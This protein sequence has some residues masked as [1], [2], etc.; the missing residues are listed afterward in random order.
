MIL[1]TPVRFQGRP[2]VLTRKP[3]AV[4]RTRIVLKKSIGCCKNSAVLCR[5]SIRFGGISTIVR[6][7]TVMFR[8][9]RFAISVFPDFTRFRWKLPGSAMIR[10]NSAETNCAVTYSDS[11]CHKVG[12]KVG[13]ATKS[14]A[15]HT[16]HANLLSST[17]TAT[18]STKLAAATKRL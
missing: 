8:Q 15:L 12:H 5:K 10:S 17:A 18:G 11:V 3:V 7:R 4:F 16:Q 6:W 14:I 9:R 2:V 13:R 1:K